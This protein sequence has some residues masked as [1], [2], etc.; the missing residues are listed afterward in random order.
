MYRKNEIKR[1]ILLYWNN[2]SIEKIL[3]KYIKTFI[4]TFIYIGYNIFTN[5]EF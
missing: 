1:K 4:Y 5:K 3:N 2:Y